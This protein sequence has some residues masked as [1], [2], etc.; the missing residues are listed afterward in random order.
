[1]E[2]QRVSEKRWQKAQSYEL[3]E[4]KNLRPLLE[5]E[6]KEIEL[7]FSNLFPVIARKVGLNDY[8][9]ILDVGSGATVPARL[10]G[11]GII[12]GLE[13]LAAKLGITGREKQ[14]EVRMVSARAE[15]MP[16]ADKTFDFVLCRN[17][18]DHMQDPRVAIREMHRVLK[19][20]G[21]MLLISYTYAPFITSVKVISEK[22]SIVR[23]IGHPHTYTPDMLDALV[24]GKFKI[25]ARYTIYT[26][27][28]S[29]DYG[30]AKHVQPDTSLIR[31]AVTWTNAYVFRS[32][33]FL[34]EYGFLSK[35]R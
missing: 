3:E 21:Y 22:F 10:F 25:I 15:H 16:F 7:K 33:W 29:T 23:N 6:W 9:Q 26:G 27:K 14:P 20:E 13:P 11:T 31:R 28:H 24:Q 8:S 2:L 32:R 12:T 17:A 4:W 18:I 34:K 5:D 19:D 30:K 1:M 35:K